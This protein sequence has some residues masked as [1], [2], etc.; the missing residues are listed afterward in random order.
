MANPEA[1]MRAAKSGPPGA[2]PGMAK[3]PMSGAPM[4]G[5]PGTPPGAPP[6]PGQDAGEGEPP[7]AGPEGAG[8]DGMVQALQGVG[9][10]LK[11]QGPG[12]AEAMGHFQALLQ[13]LSKLGGGAPPES[14]PDVAPQASGR[15]HE[16]QFPGT[17]VM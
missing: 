3:A 16:S 1:I 6:A 5:M 4:G 10:F 13:S 12:A 2:M 14:Q 7:H 11:A 15:V 8:L 9:E 17:Q